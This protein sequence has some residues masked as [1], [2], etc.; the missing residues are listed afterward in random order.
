[1]TCGWSTR[2]GRDM[3][4]DS[5]EVDWEFLAWAKENDCGHEVMA[6]A[7]ADTEHLCQRPRRFL[8]EYRH[9]WARAVVAFWKKR[10][11]LDAAV[12]AARDYGEVSERTVWNALAPAPAAPPLT[13]ERFRK[14]LVDN[15]ELADRSRN[16][17]A[18]ELLRRQL[19]KLEMRGR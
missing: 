8:A 5:N 18:A 9:V 4:A 13:E 3:S 7:L 15:L 1:M 14:I 12:V 2:H 16:R 19:K 6:K 11:K 17:A 10:G